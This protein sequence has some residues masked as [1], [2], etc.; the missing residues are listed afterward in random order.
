MDY[1]KLKAPQD[2]VTYD[3][4]KIE[5]VTGNIYL[6]ILVAAKRAE[7]ITRQIKDD[8]TAKL[9]EFQSITDTLEEITENAEQIEVS[10]F[11]ERL[12][13]PTSIALQELLENK[14]YFNITYKDIE[15]EEE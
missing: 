13:K 14:L 7:Q 6:S 9:E 4:N 5:D 15:K 1:K 11:F 12:P 10:R 8:L 2:V 3:Y